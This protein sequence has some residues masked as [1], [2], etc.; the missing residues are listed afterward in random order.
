MLL[1]PSVVYTKMEETV[2]PCCHGGC[3]WNAK[4]PRNSKIQTMK[5]YSISVYSNNFSYDL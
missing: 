4:E 1:M 2:G 3:S 5:P